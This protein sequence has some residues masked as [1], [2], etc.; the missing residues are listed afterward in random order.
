MLKWRLLTAGV[1]IPL[2]I[3]GVFAL[4]PAYFSFVM[5]L[6]TLLTA[7]EW[8]A[9]CRLNAVGQ[10]LFMGLSA[11]I[12]ALWG[13]APVPWM[14]L[15]TVLFWVGATHTVLTFKGKRPFWARSKISLPLV[16]LLCLPP[17]W[18]SFILIRA[19]SH[20]PWLILGLLVMVWMTD[21]GAYFAGK[22]FGHRKLAP[23]LSPGKTLEGL[24]GGV[25]LALGISM[26]FYLGVLKRGSPLL[27]QF[28]TTPLQ[29][30]G[31]TLVVICMS[32]IGDL[33][34][35]AVKRIQNVK[36]SGHLLP[37]HGGLLDRLDSLIATAPFFCLGL[38]W[39][40]G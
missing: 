14:L 28:D 22:T 1:L 13:S 21:I 34:E 29:W 17:F 4:S 25:V 3:W 23:R 30:G 32:V 8:A 26:A 20:G 24:V 11:L 39:F 38:L 36:D 37:G 16:G 19:E 40:K 27:S 7:R 33:F 10:I 18:A 6:I 35:S 5:A 2:V 15:V 9:L 31:L 12:M